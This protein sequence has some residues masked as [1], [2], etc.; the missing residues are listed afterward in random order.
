MR[1]H[2]YIIF[3]YIDDLVGIGP[4]STV[5][6]A[7]KF[8]LELLENLGFPISSSKLEPPSI[9]CNCLGVV[10]DTKNATLSVPQGKLLEV[11]DKCRNALGK[12]SISKQQL[13]SIIGSVKF[14]AKCVKTTRYFVNRLLNALR[15]ATNKT[16]SMNEVMK[17]YL[18]WFVTLLP[19]FNG[20]AT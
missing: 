6:N 1:Q 5:E 13:L 10:V 19:R 16:I 7:Y 9:I 12:A 8:L 14:V 18:A 4:L 17:I 11:I 3:N 2:G 15:E 20:T